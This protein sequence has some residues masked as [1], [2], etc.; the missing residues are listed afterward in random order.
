MNN[1]EIWKDHPYIKY[2]KVSTMGRFMNTKPYSIQRNI[3][4]KDR[5]GQPRN[6]IIN[7][8]VQSNGYLYIQHMGV[9]YRSHRLVA[10]T[11]ISNPYNKPYVNHKNGNK[12]DNR[13]ENLE[14]VTAKENTIHA[15]NNNLFDIKSHY[16]LNKEKLIQGS[17]EITKY[18][19]RGINLC[20][21]NNGQIIHTFNS[22]R[23]AA[24]FIINNNYSLSKSIDSVRNTL[25]RAASDN[26]RPNNAYGFL[27]QYN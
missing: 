22:S 25:I 15:I 3:Q 19:G 12:L 1:N 14:W 18:S 20:D 13:V 23:D 21:K 11:F 9:L 8:T 6:K 4:Y 26:D 24:E 7:G 5:S 16:E 27:I 17:T 2:L 10:E